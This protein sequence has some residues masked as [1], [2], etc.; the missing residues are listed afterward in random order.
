MQRLIWRLCPGLL[1]AVCCLAQT[2]NPLTWHETEGKF[3]ANNPTLLAGKVAID[4]ARADEI[5]AY[6]RPNPDLN[7]VADDLG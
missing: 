6:L 4:E 1:C 5:T 2:A 7:V 3:R